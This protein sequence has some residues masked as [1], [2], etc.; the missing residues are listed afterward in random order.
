LLP[1]VVVLA[2]SL[3]RRLSVKIAVPKEYAAE[4]GGVAEVTLTVAVYATVIDP[5]NVSTP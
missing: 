2:S 3:T 1:S 5:L 4:A